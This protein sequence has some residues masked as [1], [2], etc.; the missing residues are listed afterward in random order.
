M[1]TFSIEFLTG[2]EAPEYLRRIPAKISIEGMAKLTGIFGI[3][4]G[5]L[6]MEIKNCSV[7]R[8]MVRQRTKEMRGRLSLYCHL[9]K[10]PAYKLCE[11]YEHK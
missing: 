8:H 1:K 7:C 2:D 11:D 10:R 5:T 9:N 6:E 3:V 4:G